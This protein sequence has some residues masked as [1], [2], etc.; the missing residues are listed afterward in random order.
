VQPDPAFPTNLLAPF[1]LIVGQASFL[2]V[3]L[4]PFTITLIDEI[5]AI[6]E[7]DENFH[8]DHEVK[9][10]GEPGPLVTVQLG[11]GGKVDAEWQRFLAGKRPG[12]L[13]CLAEEEGLS[14]GEASATDSPIEITSGAVEVI[15]D[16]ADLLVRLGHATPPL[17]IEATKGA[18]NESR[19]APTNLVLCQ[20]RSAIPFEPE[21]KIMI[22]H[23]SVLVAGEEDTECDQFEEFRFEGGWI[24]LNDRAD[25]GEV[26]AEWKEIGKRMIKKGLF[27]SF[28][29]NKT[30]DGIK[31]GDHGSTEEIARDHQK[32]LIRRGERFIVK[33]A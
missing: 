32:I 25:S 6:T 1:K 15:P 16:F 31:F 27:K 11:T 28:T 9:L 7:I 30:M 24:D 10:L 8:A 14:I 26:D 18:S 13:A 33:H 19:C 23:M 5:R 2:A 12:K 4:H 20:S 29:N 17:P 21:A 3:R 22:D